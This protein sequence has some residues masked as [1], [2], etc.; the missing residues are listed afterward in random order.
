REMLNP[1]GSIC[2]GIGF[3]TVV[4]LIITLFSNGWYY[5]DWEYCGGGLD[6]TM[7]LDFGHSDFEMVVE[8]VVQI[9]PGSS[10]EQI[11]HQTVE[12][13]ETSDA[14]TIAGVDTF[15][16]MGLVLDS[17]F[18]LLIIA[19]LASIL[20]TIFSLFLAMGKGP[21]GLSFIVGL[22]TSFLI[23]IAPIHMIYAIPS[24]WEK[25]AKASAY[26]DGPWESFRGSM[27]QVSGGFLI[28]WGPGWAWYVV[29]ILGLG[30]IGASILCLKVH[31]DPKKR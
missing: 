20:F 25:M 16:Q 27:D 2:A 6:T 5:F 28:S 14:S 9:T 24:A 26:T 29:L 30:M 3:V 4:A 15:Y 31:P 10:T 11:T 7:S 17:V 23:F 12:Y 18:M 1:K 22:I 19:I 21:R 8:M 13:D